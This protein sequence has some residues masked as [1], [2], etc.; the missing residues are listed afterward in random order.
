MEK[1]TVTLREDQKTWLSD[2]PE[3]NLSGFL[4]KSLDELIRRDK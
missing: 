2:H 1:A 3:I 4:Q